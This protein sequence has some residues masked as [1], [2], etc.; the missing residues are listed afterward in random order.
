MKMTIKVYARRSDATKAFR[1]LK[2]K[3]TSQV[4]VTMYQLRD[5][6]H[7]ALQSGTRFETYA[8]FVAAAPKHLG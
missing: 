3:N 2:S 5:G 1:K 7:A 6:W 4:F 8:D